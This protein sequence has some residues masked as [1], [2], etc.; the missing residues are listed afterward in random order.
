MDRDLN[1]HYYNISDT[2]RFLHPDDKVIKNIINTTDTAYFLPLRQL[3]C[4]GIM[5]HC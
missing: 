1:R 2:G 3:I 4:R 5:L